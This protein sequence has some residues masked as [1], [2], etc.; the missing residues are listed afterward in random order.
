[1]T[2]DPAVAGVAWDAATLLEE[3]ASLLGQVTSGRPVG[4]VFRSVVDRLHERFPGSVC[5]SG[6]LDH[7]GRLD[8]CFPTLA[9]PAELAVGEASIADP[10]VLGTEPCC[11]LGPAADPRCAKFAH[12]LAELN[13]RSLW[14]HPLLGPLDPLDREHAIGASPVLGA[15]VVMTPEARCPDDRELAYLDR[16]AKLLA[17]ALEREGLRARLEHGALHDELT[18]LPNR[19]RMMEELD[20]AHPSGRLGVLLID[21]DRFK[22]VNDTHGHAAGNDVLCAVADALA[23]PLPGGSVAGRHG[24]DEFSVALLDTDAAGLEAAAAEVCTRVREHLRR[25]DVAH[26]T[27]VSVGAT[28]A[29]PAEPLSAALE[30]AD[31]AL[32]SVK[33]RGR[34]GYAVV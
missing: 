8:L 13:V 17:L 7:F 3:A 24:G 16:C 33:D 5:G 21:L 25:I 18:G 1:M 32:Y 26:A 2:A 31:Q 4:E 23:R 27:S 30:R 9:R 20:R 11:I 14:A 12:V 6:G 22:D 28:V 19:R 10:E 34:D 29:D 15:L